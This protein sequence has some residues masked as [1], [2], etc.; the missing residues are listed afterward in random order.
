MIKGIKEMNSIA[1]T[2][3][4][5]I[6]GCSFSLGGCSRKTETKQVME[7]QENRHHLDQAGENFETLGYAMALDHYRRA[8]HGNESFKAKDWK[9]YLI[10]LRS[11]P[12]VDEA[13]KRS[14]CLKVLEQGPDLMASASLAEIAQQ[15]GKTRVARHYWEQALIVAIDEEHSRAIHRNLG[16]LLFRD[17]N[18]SVAHH[19]LERYVKK[20]KSTGH[21]PGE[22]ETLILTR[23]RQL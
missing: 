19:H 8:Q 21:R 7:V 3:L 16:I 20:C 1:K 17:G 2:T 18:Y 23:L 5:F 12:E 9:N 6:L 4:I 22:R 11:E 13:E 15:Q 14:V 10:C